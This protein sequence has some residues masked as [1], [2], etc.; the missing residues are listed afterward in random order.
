MK[1]HGVTNVI[2]SNLGALR[3]QQSNERR[4]NRRWKCC[5]KCQKDKSPQGGF[6]RIF[7]SVHKFICKDCMDAKKEL[8]DA[9]TQ[10]T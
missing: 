5:W 1:G 2:A 10:T 8:Q 7:G 6:L 4:M 3:S 9:K